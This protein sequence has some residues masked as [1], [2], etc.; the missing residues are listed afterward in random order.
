MSKLMIDGPQGK[1][2]TLRTGH[3]RDRPLVFLHA[4]PGRASQWAAVVARLAP[5]HDTV[6]FD[7]RGAGNSA[8]ARNG[9]YSIAGRADDLAAAVQA[10]GLTDFVI[11]AHS[12]AAAVALDYAGAN[13]G[14]V[15]GIVMVDPAT[16]PRAMPD[17]LR[18][19]FVRDMAGPDSLAAFQAYVGSIAGDTLAV[20]EQ[21]LADAAVLG[22]EARA[23]LAA[24]FSDWNPETALDAY[25]GP[26]FILCTP[27]TDIDGA[28]YRLRPSIPYQ[29]IQ[30]KGH[31]LQ[32]DHPDVV[33]NAIEAFRETLNPQKSCAHPPVL[34]ESRA[35]T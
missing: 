1:L 32:L 15:A 33:A 13:P 25:D 35:F 18:T 21:V 2:S 5:N 31:W 12:A 6:I 16:D 26:I 7:F 8:P 27:A 10:F 22:P 30:T 28:L 20:R 9:D 11:V 3:G 23:G 34:Q 24:A 4:D 17:E 14:S 19:E 29:V